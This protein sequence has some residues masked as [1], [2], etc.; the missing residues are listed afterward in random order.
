MEEPATASWDLSISDTDLDKLKAGFM[1]QDMDDKWRITVTDQSQ[2]GTSSIHF[3]RSWT[4]IEHYVL[5]VKSNDGGSSGGSGGKIEAITWEQNKGGIRITEELAKKE[6]VYMSR[7]LLECR[8]E[9]LPEYSFEE[10]F[11]HPGT[12]IT[13]GTSS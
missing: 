4:G 2:E 13:N 5:F 3:A 11:D 8:F 9:A 12:Y 10:V 7:N 6:V 1:P